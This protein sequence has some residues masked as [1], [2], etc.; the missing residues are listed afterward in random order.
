MK[1]IPLHSIVLLIGT[2]KSDFVNDNF[3]NYEILKIN[4]IK[5]EIIGHSVRY[6]IAS[7]LRSELLRRSELKL[8]L[9]ERVVVDY[10]FFNKQNRE[11]F[12]DLSIKYG[13]PI[14]YVVDTNTRKTITNDKKNLSHLD[15]KEIMKGD[16]HATVIDINNDDVSV[17]QKPFTMELSSFLK[18]NGYNGVMAIGDIHG[19]SDSL[20]NAIEWATVRNLFMIFLGD[21]VDYG[22]KP[23]E[24]IDMVYD[25]VMRGRGVL[26][27]GNHERKIFR[28][29]NQFEMGNVNLML[30]DGN[31]VT[32]NIFK[33]LSK[34]DYEKY[35]L[36]FK[37][38]YH[39][40]R[41][42]WK[43]GNILFV[44]GGAEP[45]MFDLDYEKLYGKYETIALFGELSDFGD[46]NS[47]PE[48]SYNW[49]NRIP[50]NH[51][52]IVGHDIR[53]TFKPLEVIGSLGGKAIFL[54]TGCGK[55]GTLTSYDIVLTDT[56]FK[57]QNFTRF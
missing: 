34:E 17:V 36:K 11:N 44:H 22:P 40:S 25:I 30:S 56:G 32:T 13:I 33:T 14:F 18:D 5:N 3:S 21:I 7:L 8:S 54:D 39:I 57:M 53:S 29:L 6:D 4:N 15:Y 12:I 37:S 42:H 49:V 38:L 46:R 52:V 47:H 27:I 23:L 31:K 10:N 48:R 51:T 9:G 45:E 50:K 26:T 1:K 24:C 2:S 41:H 19:M 43:L 20:K 35:S 55:G 28:W 16:S